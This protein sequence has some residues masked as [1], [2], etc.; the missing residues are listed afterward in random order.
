MAAPPIP[1]VPIQQLPAAY[2]GVFSTMLRVGDRLADQIVTTRVTQQ[3]RVKSKF[4]ATC[5]DHFDVLL[6]QW[7]E[8]NTPDPLVRYSMGQRIL[9]LECRITIGC[10]RYVLHLLRRLCF[11]SQLTP[12]V[13]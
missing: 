5:L 8:E 4:R 3:T 2:H 1:C 6:E 11:P 9:L 12:I 13:L 10:C 7:R